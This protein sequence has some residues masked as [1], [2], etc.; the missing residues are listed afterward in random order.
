[1]N[2]LVTVDAA[3]TLRVRAADGS[4]TV[5]LDHQAVRGGTFL[6][7]LPRVPRIPRFVSSSR[8]G[9]NGSTV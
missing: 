3:V 1:M 4:E 5:V 6:S 7:S 9:R 8:T 2:Y